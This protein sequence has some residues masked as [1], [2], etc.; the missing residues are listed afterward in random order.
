MSG[1]KRAGLGNLRWRRVAA[2]ALG[3]I[4]LVLGAAAWIL[5]ASRPSVDDDA[6]DFDLVDV[7]GNSVS[8]AAE[9]YHG[10]VVLVNIWGLWCPPCLQEIPYLI[11]LQ[12]EYGPRGFEIIG[13]EFASYY[14]DS[15][16]D[17]SR[18][19][20]EWAKAQDINYTIV[21]GGRT[22]EVESVFPALRGFGGFPTSVL[23]A[24]DGSVRMMSE[25]FAPSEMQW[26]EDN[27]KKLL[28]EPAPNENHATDAEP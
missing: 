18:L 22:N 26:F 1:V 12:K 13:V 5:G 10:K 28:R 23:I 2:G 14:G 24:R 17:Y 21:Q 16:E 27:I 7:D 11:D 3:G 15:R 20:R 8:L 25:G 9:R 4:A 6:L 19:L